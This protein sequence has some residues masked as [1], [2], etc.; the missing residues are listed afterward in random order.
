M[1]YSLAIHTSSPELGFALDNFSGDRRQQTWDLGRDVSNQ[2][3]DR[4]QQFLTPQ[5]W[6]DL[7]FI[8]VAIGPGGFTGTRLGV[9]LARTLGQQLQIP[10]FGI[11]S[12]AAIAQ[13]AYQPPTEAMTIAVQMPAQ[14]N[15]LYTAIYQIK[16]TQVSNASMITP[17]LSDSVMSPA[18]WERLS[19]E[20]ATCIVA[21]T[22]QG[23]YATQLLT[24]AQQLWQNGD[25]PHWQTALPYYGQH[26]VDD[27][28]PPTKP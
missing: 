27:I 9:V 4:L 25:R 18:Q 5:T 19:H 22:N 7:A 28:P 3:H 26:P 8:A 2:L 23:Q 16:N 12:L 10:V 14:R 11:S 20:A 1:N 13:A 21:P 24:I 15:E 17:Q 6:S